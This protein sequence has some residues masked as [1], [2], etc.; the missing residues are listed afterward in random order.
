MQ[1]WL[2]LLST[3][4]NNQLKTTRGV[5]GMRKLVL[6]IASVILSSG[7]SDK[8]IAENL[9]DNKA[10]AELVDVIK[11]VS[12]KSLSPVKEISIVGLNENTKFTLTTYDNIQ[13][14]HDVKLNGRID[15]WVYFSCDKNNKCEMRMS[16]ET[17]TD[18]I[19]KDFDIISKKQISKLVKRVNNFKKNTD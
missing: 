8:N 2:K 3:A 6:I 13:V 9:L 12:D 16:D 19:K 10:T 7:C 4:N 11:A 18:A 1:T 15:W 5:N 14:E 17:A